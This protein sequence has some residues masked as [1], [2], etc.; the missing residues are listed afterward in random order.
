MEVQEKKMLEE[1]ENWTVHKNL[2]EQ[3]RRSRWAKWK[4]KAS[5]NNFHG[6]R[7]FGF[8]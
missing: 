1:T 4:K 5:S 3:D 7:K 8:N 2:C 6:E